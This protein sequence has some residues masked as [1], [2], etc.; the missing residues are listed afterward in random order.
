MNGIVG[1]VDG[2]GSCVN[3][4]IFGG[5]QSF[6]AGGLLFCRSGCRFSGRLLRDFLCRSRRFR[7]RLIHQGLRRRLSLAS[8]SPSRTSESPVGFRPAVRAVFA[9]SSGDKIKSSVLNLQHTA[10]ADSVSVGLDV[11]AA[12]RN[13]HKAEGNIAVMLTVDSVLAGPDV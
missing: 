5:L 2:E 12:A 9:A 11:K 3:Q 4:Q 13:I 10:G 8:A 7:R 6:H 1:R